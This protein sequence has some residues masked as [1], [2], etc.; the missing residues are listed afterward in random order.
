[1]KKY[2]IVIGLVLAVAFAITGWVLY[3]RNT[4]HPTTPDTP[5]P[6]QSAEPTPT[7]PPMPTITVAPAE[8]PQ[9]TPTPEPKEETIQTTDQTNQT[10]EETTP[11]TQTELNNTQTERKDEYNGWPAIPESQLP[12]PDKK[13]TDV[14]I[15]SQ[16]QY[17]NYNGN[18]VVITPESHTTINRS[19]LDYLAESI[20]LLTN[21]E[22]EARGVKKLGYAYDLQDAAD[23]RAREASMQFSHTRPNGQSCHEIITKD[24][25]VTGENLIMADKAVASAENMVAE[26]MNSEGHRYNILLKD[27]R[28]L[29]VGVYEANGVV[30]VCQLFC[31]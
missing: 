10:N 6:V 13:E 24:C 25:F 15:P 21:Q 23:T 12:Q 3:F 8:T 14:V 1:M 18:Y 9:P 30:Y 22:R 31:G 11:K 19:S 26:W 20:F 28:E 7:P 29:A 16:N 4:P 2:I 5:E 27:F 17:V